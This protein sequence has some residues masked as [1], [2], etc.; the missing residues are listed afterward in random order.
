MSKNIENL[1]S[2][3]TDIALGVTQRSHNSVMIEKD[4]TVAAR[5]I[6]QILRQTFELIRFLESEVID[7]DI[8]EI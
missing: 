2:F 5:E 4:V 3:R 1:Q 6:H 7:G 8:K